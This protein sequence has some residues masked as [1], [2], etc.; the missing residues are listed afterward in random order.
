MR[1][2]SRFLPKGDLRPPSKLGQSRNIE[3]LT[4]SAI[5]LG[6][7]ENEASLVVNHRH[8]EFR[9]LPYGHILTPTDIDYRLRS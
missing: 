2:Y 6:A 8:N 1:K 3:Q 4:W 9:K 7:I 5:R